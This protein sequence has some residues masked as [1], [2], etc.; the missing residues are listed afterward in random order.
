MERTPQPRTR[1]STPPPGTRG[2][3]Y[4]NLVRPGTNYRAADA[5]SALPAAPLAQPV[6][7]T[8]LAHE[9]IAP[10]QQQITQPAPQPPTPA[11]TP[12]AIDLS[13]APIPANPRQLFQPPDHQFT[14]VQPP[15]HQP[16]NPHPDLN[17]ELPDDDAAALTD[18]PAA[19]NRHLFG[20]IF[21]KWRSIRSSAGNYYTASP[22]RAALLVS[23]SLLVL[24][25]IGWTI[26]MQSTTANELFAKTPFG[27]L[28]IKQGHT[29]GEQITVDE[30][31]P[32]AEQIA[33]YQVPAS[34]PRYI[35]IPSISLFTR[36]LAL[37][38]KGEGIELPQNIYDVGWST[39]SNPPTDPQG[40]Q[41]Y[42]GHTKGLTKT[43]AAFAR[44]NELK[45]GNEIVVETGGGIKYTYVVMHTEKANVSSPNISRYYNSWIVGKPGLN[46]LTT[47]GID[48]D[49]DNPLTTRYA[50]LAVFCVLKTP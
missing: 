14:T 44:L 3:D 37:E 11:T 49:Q 45:E 16:F 50:T 36:V 21:N 5:T 30:N 42:V 34:N 23:S 6:T 19:A 29:K 24:S 48:P 27:F 1:F 25:A 18:E 47:S 2:R 41:L 22:K 46:L 40:T 31:K 39:Q 12:Q 9:Q 35:S 10:P 20:R 4:S 28:L 8:P 7:P 15:V 13:P 26:A 43:D 32:T 17:T 33:A 38:S